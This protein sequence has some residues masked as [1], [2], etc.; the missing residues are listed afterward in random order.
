MGQKV[1]PHGLRVG[2]IKG[3]DTQ[4]YADKKK[5]AAY[6]K[7]DHTI[8]TF[9]K[10]KYYH[11][12]ISRI[13]IERAAGKLVVNIHTGR[14]GVLNGKNGAEKEELQRTIRKIADRGITVL[15]VEHDMKLVMN[16]TE[17][18]CVINFGKR[19][20]FGTPEEIQNNPDVIEAYLGGGLD[21]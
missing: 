20:A 4:W 19:I 16:V 6:L 14:I 12:A 10:K 3:W 9:I 21:V 11:A 15:L 13:L 8:R 5:F 18:I 1:N 7:E 17:Q 2:I